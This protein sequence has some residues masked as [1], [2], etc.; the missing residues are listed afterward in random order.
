[1]QFVMFVAVKAA[2][3]KYIW[4]LWILVL[5]HIQLG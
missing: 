4:K 1:M 5:F 3:L 2:C